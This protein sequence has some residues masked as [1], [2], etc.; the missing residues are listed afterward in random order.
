MVQ[1][2]ILAL[3]LFLKMELL[4]TTTQSVLSTWIITWSTF[5]WS[6]EP[7]SAWNIVWITN[8]SYTMWEI[9]QLRWGKTK[10]FPRI[11]RDV[12][13]LTTSSASRLD[14]SWID[15][16]WGVQFMLYV[17]RLSIQFL[18]VLYECL[19]SVLVY[20]YYRFLKD[21]STNWKESRRKF[22]T[23]LFCR[24]ML[25]LSVHSLQKNVTMSYAKTT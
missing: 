10:H 23:L 16:V 11:S 21:T 2:V 1:N 20:R 3:F 24:A 7:F 6:L 8:E 17:M 4:G 25:V 9:S 13:F 15:D 18:L 14:Q 5:I 22:A 12:T 19:A